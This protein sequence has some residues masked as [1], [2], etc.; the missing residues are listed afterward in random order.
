MSTYTYVVQAFRRRVVPVVCAAVTAI[1]LVAALPASEGSAAVALVATRTTCD[2]AVHLSQWTL[3]RL[4]AQVVAM[5]VEADQVGSFAREARTGYGGIL[6]FGTS[7][8]ASIGATLRQ[9]QASSPQ[10][11]GISVMTDEEGGDVLRLDN[12]VGPFPWARTMARTMSSAEITS[13]ARRVGTQLRKAGVTMDLA[14]VLDVDGRNVDPGVSDPDGYR[15]F[16]G[17]VPVVVT[18]GEAFAG[19][20]SAA[21]V[22]PVVKHFPGLGGS[23]GNTDDG[24]AATKPWAVLKA[25]ALHT[26]ETAI[27]RGAPA[28]MVANARVPGLTALPASLSSA[29]MVGVLRNWL[30]FKGL[31]MTDTLTAGA[32]SAVPLSVQAAAADA[33][34]AGADLVLLGGQPSAGA[35]VA[36]SISVSQAI[37]SAV[38]RGRLSRATLVGAVTH[39]LAVRGV[40][41]CPGE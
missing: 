2:A 19:G 5:P 25:S 35:D 34:I 13:T 12:L 17:T 14:P 29:V 21:G 9:L 6:L 36:L 15:S 27:N 37:V 28:I 20:L 41:V 10:D 40:E 38:N 11:L 31:I 39:D 1:S 22:T 18:D 24:P 4:S 3:N 30:H 16:G 33:I 8:P 23:T 26:F 32:I 7:A